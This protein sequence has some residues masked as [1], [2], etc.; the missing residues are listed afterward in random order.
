LRLF[1]AQVFAIP[2][3]FFSWMNTIQFLDIRHINDQ[4]E[5]A[6]KAAVFVLIITLL[7]LT[8]CKNSTEPEVQPVTAAKDTLILKYDSLGAF[9]YSQT[10]MT[11][12]YGDNIYIYGAQ[13]KL[14]V[15]NTVTKTMTQSS[16][17]TDTMTWRWD[18]AFVNVDTMM[19]IFAISNGKTAYDKVLTFNPRTNEIKA[20]SVP[21]LFNINLYPA[22][23]VSGKKILLLYPNKD[24]LYAF[25]TQSMTGQF[26]SQNKM[27]EAFNS[28]VYSSG[29]Y[30]NGFYVYSIGKKQMYRIDMSTYAWQE[31]V[32]PDSIKSN[33][34]QYAFGGV[35]SNKFVLINNTSSGTGITVAYNLSTKQWLLG[36][37]NTVLPVSEASMI[38]HG[39]AIYSADVFAKS[40]WKVSLLTSLP[41]P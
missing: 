11:A 31:I 39:G 17:A 5:S 28:K 3:A 22:A 18:G 7:A 24:S 20:T 26:V 36:K 15:Y 33:I 21:L 13:G 41:T 32:I 6:M 1:P 8:S 23:A 14:S 10:L 2:G 40:L 25:D 35:I 30:Q 4:K 34:N 37:K 38:T 19:Y 9:P 29:V 12:G 16:T 27:K